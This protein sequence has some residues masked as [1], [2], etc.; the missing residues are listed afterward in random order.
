MTETVTYDVVG[1]TCGQCKAA[2]ER[3]LHRIRGVEEVKVE[4]AA[5]QVTVQGRGLD[6]ERL[7]VAIDEA[8]YF[9]KP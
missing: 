3:E 1:M 5:H 4:L 7:R 8:G 9:V 2:I 6:D